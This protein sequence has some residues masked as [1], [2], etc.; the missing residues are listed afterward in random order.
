MKYTIKNI[1]TD[2]LIDVNHP[3]ILKK[4]I[5]LLRK[6]VILLQNN[7]NDN[8]IE[9]NNIFDMK[10]KNIKNNIFDKR[11]I[12]E[13]SKARYRQALKRLKNNNKLK[14]LH[15]NKDR[16]EVKEVIEENYQNTQMLFCILALVV[17]IKYGENKT[18]KF[19][20][21]LYKRELNKRK[22]K[23][24]TKTESEDR[25][26][27]PKSKLDETFDSIFKNKEDL[28]K[29]QLLDLVL[30]GLYTKQPPRRNDYRNMLIL[31]NNEDYNEL[32]NDLN[33]YNI[34]TGE[35]IFNVYKTSNRYGTQRINIKDPD[36]K[37]ILEYYIDLYN[38]KYLLG[39]RIFKSDNYSHKLRNMSKKLFNKSTGSSLYRKIFISSISKDIHIDDRLE[40]SNS[41]AHSLDTALVY[42]TKI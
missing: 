6:K 42:Y 9:Q 28:N 20:N 40:I 5:N 3:K 38:P 16:F 24:R 29:K 30:L 26:W 41:M 18:S 21:S 8:N 10:I 17:N 32:S 25:N 27:I 22:L 1:L 34:N 37:D 36:L 31:Y 2:E 4:Y 23:S 13:T 12:K 15:L 35:F 14:E 7:N 19:Y 33:Y 39:N 11:N